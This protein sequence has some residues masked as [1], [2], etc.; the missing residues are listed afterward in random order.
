MVE[1]HAKGGKGDIP[2]TPKKCHPFPTE[3]KNLPDMETSA[4]IVSCT[5]VIPCGRGRER[6]VQSL[7]ALQS[8]RSRR[9]ENL[10]PFA[11][12]CTVPAL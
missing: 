10:Y 8:V 11:S 4:F 5:N 9:L 2:G 1:R 3:V 12:T 6:R 7:M